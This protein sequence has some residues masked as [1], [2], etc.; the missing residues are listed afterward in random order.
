MPLSELLQGEG[1]RNLLE[2]SVMWG[3]GWKRHFRKEGKVLTGLGCLE[4]DSILLNRIVMS[5]HCLP[6]LVLDI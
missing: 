2:E 3:M 1:S 5:I 4:T 6:D